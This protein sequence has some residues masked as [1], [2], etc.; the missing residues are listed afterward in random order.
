MFFSYVTLVG[1]VLMIAST[2]LRL[3]GRNFISFVSPETI[4]TS[5]AGFGVGGRFGHEYWPDYTW[6]TAAAGMIILGGTWLASD[7]ARAAKERK[8]SAEQ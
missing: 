1:A 2:V 5:I 8:L 7:F 4:S 6:A 3:N